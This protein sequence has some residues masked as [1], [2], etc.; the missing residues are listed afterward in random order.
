MEFVM[1]EDINDY[2]VCPNCLSKDDVSLEPPEKN[3]KLYEWYC[4][5][6]DFAWILEDKND[7][8]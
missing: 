8:S 4:S 3:G 2:P 7:K 5:S 6:C 1:N